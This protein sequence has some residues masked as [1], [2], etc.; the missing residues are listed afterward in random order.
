MFQRWTRLDRDVVAGASV[1][2]PIQVNGKVRGEVTV[3]PG[4][5]QEQVEAAAQE[6]DN[7]ARYLKQGSVEKVF[8]I[9]GRMVNFVVR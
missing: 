5:S 9:E 4:T 1:V 2:E 6:L 8:Y 7:V 3:A